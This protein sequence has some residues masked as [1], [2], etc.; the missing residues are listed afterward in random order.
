MMVALPSTPRVLLAVARVAGPRPAALASVWAPAL[1][2]LLPSVPLVLLSV[3]QAVGPGPAAQASV[4]APAL[5]LL[6]AR[7]VELPPSVLV[8]AWAPTLVV[9]LPMVPGLC[10]RRARFSPMGRRF[11]EQPVAPSR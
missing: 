4:G 5:V 6:P 1:A 7:T 3:A 9:L 10:P 8:A 11:A 2:V